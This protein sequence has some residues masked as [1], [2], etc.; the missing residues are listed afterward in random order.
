MLP[1]VCFKESSLLLQTPRHVFPPPPGSLIITSA[2]RPTQKQKR[3][4][5]G[6]TE[7]SSRSSAVRPYYSQDREEASQNVNRA[8]AAGKAQTSR[9]KHPNELHMK[10]GRRGAVET[11]RGAKTRQ[12]VWK[13]AC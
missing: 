8:A 12:R 11:G 3:R 13:K 6:P 4:Q 9:D 1:A 10:A 5:F 7:R 2:A